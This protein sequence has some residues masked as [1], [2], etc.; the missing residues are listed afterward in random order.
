MVWV[1]LSWELSILKLDFIGE[2]VT[3]QTSV[4][5]YI[6]KIP[7]FLNSSACNE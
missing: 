1:E 2:I 7:L 6:L 5:L 3:M 4:T